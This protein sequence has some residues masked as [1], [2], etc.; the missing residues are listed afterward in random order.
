MFSYR[1]R[2]T[3]GRTLYMVARRSTTELPAQRAGPLLVITVLTLTLVSVAFSARLHAQ[4][5]GGLLTWL[6][7]PP[8]LEGTELFATLQGEIGPQG[9]S[10]FKL[11]YVLEADIFPH[12]ILAYG[13][14][15]S[16][17]PSDDSSSD[18]ET[19][20]TLPTTSRSWLKP[21]ISVTPAIRLRMLVEKSAPV[22]APSFMPRAN[23]QDSDRYKVFNFNGVTV[24]NSIP[25]ETHPGPARVRP[26]VPWSP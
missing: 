25:H 19:D 8:L 24:C 3:D 5:G 12:F 26:S 9:D 14:R 18:S 11:P 6:E 1:R 2:A 20:L 4:D 15:C 10:Q 22:P 21:C 23:A 7:P 16:N 17:V 13:N